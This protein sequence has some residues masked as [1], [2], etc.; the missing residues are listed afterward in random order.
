MNVA[1]KTSALRRRSQAVFVL[2][3]AIF[4]L[5]A[6]SL[7]ATAGVFNPG[8][9]NSLIAN[10]GLGDAD[11]YI[12]NGDSLSPFD[13]EHP[14]VTNLDPALLS[15]VQ[16]AAKDASRAGISIKITAGW[17]ST[18]YQQALLDDAIASYGSVDQARKWVNTP[19][20]STHVT[21]NAVDIGPTNAD[22]WLSQ[23]GSD[24]GLCQTYANEIWHFELATTPGGQCPRMV[25]DAGSDSSQRQERPS[26]P[27]H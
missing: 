15:A 5:T 10:A 24:Y 14:A 11:G 23:H 22:S 6:C 21:A 3:T 17:R 2:S 8:T 18:R 1:P 4:V 16:K 27:A 19:D 26:L 9:S 20:K 25:S 12:A 7:G 13:T